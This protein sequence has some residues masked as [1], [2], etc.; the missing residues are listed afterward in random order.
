MVQTESEASSS[1]QPS[2]EKIAEKYATGNCVVKLGLSPEDSSKV[3]GGED[4]HHH[5]HHHHH[6]VGAGAGE[7]PCADTHE[8]IISTGRDVSRYLVDVRDDGETALTFR[9]FVIGTIF[10]G[11]G[12]TLSQVSCSLWHHHSP[13]DRLRDPDIQLQASPDGGFGHF[14]AITSL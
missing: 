11:L 3:E 14:P 12:A 10:A 7:R 9:S 13:N 1:R 6:H 2:A 8:H 4:H 5:H